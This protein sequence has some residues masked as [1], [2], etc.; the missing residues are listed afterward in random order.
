MACTLPSRGATPICLV[1]SNS[2]EGASR[3]ARFPK[4]G[5]K[6]NFVEKPRNCC[7]TVGQHAKLEYVGV[8]RVA[9]ATL[10]CVLVV[11]FRS[12][13]A[14]SKYSEGIGAGPSLRTPSNMCHKSRTAGRTVQLKRVI[15]SD[16]AGGTPS[17]S[18]MLRQCSLFRLLRFLAPLRTDEV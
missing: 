1:H 13:H 15:T 5:R 11:Y 6:K 14:Y 16:A 18:K 2:F 8:T 10:R 17:L 7:S 9:L 4:R 12:L 3:R